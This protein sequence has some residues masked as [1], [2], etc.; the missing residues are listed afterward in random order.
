MA[1]VKNLR[2]VRIALLL[3]VVTLAG[4][5]IYRVL[6]TSSVVIKL[7]DNSPIIGTVVKIDGEYLSPSGE[8]ARS[9]I[10]KVGLG[11]HLIEVLAPKY[12]TVSTTIDTGF[13]SKKN[14]SVELL[15]EDSLSA[16]AIAKEL[17]QDVKD[18]KVSNARLYGDANWLTFSVSSAVKQSE[19]VTVVAR[20]S[21][22]ESAWRVID[23]GTSID[24]LSDQIREAPLDLRRSLE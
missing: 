17:Y 12:K 4:Y 7:D 20:Y 16:E 15:P 21:P 1:V 24:V 5:F 23:S 11:N 9:Y 22:E 19:I 18:V 14:V 6:T 3:A 2:F 13:L 10:A 8:G